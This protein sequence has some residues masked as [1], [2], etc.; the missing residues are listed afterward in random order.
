[1]LPPSGTGSFGDTLVA[2]LVV[3]AMLP[4]AGIALFGPGPL[5]AAARRRRLLMLLGLS[6]LVVLTLSCDFP[7]IGQN[8]TPSPSPS[9]SPSTISACQAA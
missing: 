3:T 1:M 2:G 5:L 6:A 4:I 8:S 9:A 7:A